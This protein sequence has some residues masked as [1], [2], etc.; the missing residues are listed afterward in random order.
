MTPAGV[1]HSSV[2]FVRL[3]FRVAVLEGGERAGNC[4]VCVVA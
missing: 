1:L 3:K 4:V 2:D